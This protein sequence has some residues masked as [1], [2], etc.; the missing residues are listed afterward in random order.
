MEGKRW[1]EAFSRSS[2]LV[3]NT[4][5]RVFVVYAAIVLIAAGLG[6]VLGITLGLVPWIGT[7]LVMILT[8][9]IVAVGSTILYYDLVSRKE[10][11]RPEMAMSLERT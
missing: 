11:Y 7:S 6:S 8:A 3:R 10:G 5:W 4:W 1:R 9:P 2:T